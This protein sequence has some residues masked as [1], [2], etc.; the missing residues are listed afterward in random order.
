VDDVEYGTANHGKEGGDNYVE[1]TLD[2]SYVTA[3][4]A[5]V[6]TINSNTN[7]S[8]A[9]EEGEA[10]GVATVFAMDQIAARTTDLPLV[11]SLSLGSLGFDSCDALCTELSST[12]KFSY[13]SCHDY[14]QKQRQICLYASYKQQD[15]INTAFKVMGCAGLLCRRH[16]SVVS[17]LLPFFAFCPSLLSSA[18]F[19]PF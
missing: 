13:R 6:R 5:G 2:T 12:T 3:F 17:L 1:G 11:L 7:T 19:L 4:G 16:L 8:M 18:S 15:R 14:I 9:T 10:Q